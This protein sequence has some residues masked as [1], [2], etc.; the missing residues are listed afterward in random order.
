MMMDVC[1][2]PGGRIIRLPGISLEM[3]AW[4][5]YLMLT[6]LLGCG[7]AGYAQRDW[8]WV[9]GDSVVMRF[10]NGGA[11]VVDSLAS[12]VG[13]FEMGACISDTSGEILMY[14]HR[15]SSYNRLR[16]AIPG[17][18]L[19]FCDES[20][21]QGVL[22]IEDRTRHNAIHMFN[23]S[24][25]CGTGNCLLHSAI[26]FHA[27][28]ANGTLV[29]VK[30]ERFLQV[31]PWGLAEHLA[32]TYSADG[33]SIWVA[34]HKNLSDEFCILEIN[35]DSI[36][37][38]LVQPIGSD[39]QLVGSN[40]FMNIGEMTFS[41]DGTK[42]L[43]V[44]LTGIIDV[45]DFDRCTG[46]LSNWR[47][48][49]T[50]ANNE[51]GPDTYYGC[52][53]SPDGTKIYVS[54]TNNFTIGN[55]L[56]QFDLNTATSNADRALIYT[57]PAEMIVG[58]HQ[59]GPDGKIYITHND[60]LTDTAVGNFAL[61]VLN[62]PNWFGGQFSYASLHLKGKQATLNLP[63]LTNY[64]LGPSIA[65]T[66][67]AGPD[68]LICRG[69]S[70]LLGHPDSTAGR[71]GYWW[72]GPGISSPQAAL[73]WVRPDSTAWYELQAM[74][75]LYG[76][77][78][79]WTWDSVLVVVE[80]GEWIV[81]SL[82][83]AVTVCVG[84]SLLVGAGAVAGWD[85]HWSGPGW[86]GSPDSASTVVAGAGDYVLEG[87]NPSGVGDCFLRQDTVRVLDYPWA[88]P[89]DAA[90]A[91]VT[92]CAGDTVRLGSGAWG[93]GPDWVVGWTGAALDSADVARPLAWPIGTTEYVLAGMDTAFSGGCA[94]VRDTVMVTVEDQNWQDLLNL[95]DLHDTTYCPGECFTIG[96]PPVAGFQYQWSPLAG[97][98]SPNASMTR[99]QP[100]GTTTYTL[101]V[102]NPA[103][104]SANCRERRFVV[105]VVADACNHQSFIAVN[106]NN[107][108][109][110]LDLGDHAGRVELWVWDMAGRLI[111][112]DGNYR[113]DW[114]ADGASS[115]SAAY[116]A[117]GLYVYRVNIMGDCPNSYTGRLAILR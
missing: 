51:I 56:F 69:D 91:D 8:T 9:F 35:G 28:S 83:A 106:G 70:V 84:D 16:Q 19:I 11:P 22:L 85:Y 107:V 14:A 89:P 29:G 116:L 27:D 40:P 52:S 12:S 111:Y 73:T 1:K 80:S 86:I 23:L 100:V 41:H 24:F 76:R 26:Q 42:L 25:G 50:Y 81:D 103:Q 71:V 36:R 45:F 13:F 37:R 64:N 4:T 59:L 113:N 62:Q 95:Q 87:V 38:Q 15:D 93:L 79:G 21:T 60:F 32:A 48:L 2:F 49:G 110:V 72:S 112:F 90:G 61:S 99:A 94:V 109:E 115:A 33:R 30:Q 105:E 47:E 17:G 102:T 31:S 55:R 43:V 117:H 114:K 67:E 97:L 20:T 46:E 78:C 54:E 3:R 6:W 58:Q 82:E 88:A 108:A 68:R 98:S 65:Q 75:S 74:D 44:T 18:D 101:I 57:F 10:P 96:V 92:V 5:K 66:A 104:Q 63:N 39:R 77:Q 53:F 7:L 34:T